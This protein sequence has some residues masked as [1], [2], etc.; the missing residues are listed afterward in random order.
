MRS[1]YPGNTYAVLSGTSMATPHIA[2][3][4]AL[5]YAMK[6]QLIGD[7]DGT[8]ALINTTAHHVNSAACSSNGTYPNNLYGYGLVD[9]A[10]AVRA[11]ASDRPRLMR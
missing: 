6:P 10:A 3:V 5:I 4:I 1:A 8:E 9:A 11:P 7:V 2:G